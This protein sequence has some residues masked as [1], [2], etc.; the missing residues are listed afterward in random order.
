[1]W[2]FYF[3]ILKIKRGKNKIFDYIFIKLVEYSEYNGSL[4]ANNKKRM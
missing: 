2:S 3:D 1:M 4:V